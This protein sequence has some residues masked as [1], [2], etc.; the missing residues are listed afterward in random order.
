MTTFNPSHFEHEGVRYEAATAL[1][2]GCAGCEFAPIGVFQKPFA[3]H[4]IDLMGN[5]SSG[6]A[7]RRKTSHEHH[8]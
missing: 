7:P 3:A 5:S 8:V 4:Q 2:P 6:S 1:G